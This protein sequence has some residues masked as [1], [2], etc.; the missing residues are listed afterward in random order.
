MIRASVLLVLACLALSE[1][2]VGCSCID[3]ERPCE[4]LRTDAVFV[5]R[6]IETV[7]VK[8]PLEKK[9]SWTVG[10]SMRFAVDES[11]RGGLGTEATIETGNGGGDC[12]TPLEPGGRFLIFAYGTRAGSSGPGCVAETGG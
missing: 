12:G 10:Y 5:G 3:T 8:H 6:V 7:S 2:C 11:L 4:N 9:D 1:G